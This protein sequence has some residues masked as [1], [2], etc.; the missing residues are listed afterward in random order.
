MI[1][2]SIVMRQWRRAQTIQSAPV[3]IEVPDKVRTAH[4][5][6]LAAWDAER[7][8]TEAL[9]AEPSDAANTRG[10][11]PDLTRSPGRR[12]SRRHGAREPQGLLK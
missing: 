3:A 5:A 10:G 4:G 7:G 9:R 2:A 12:T 8:E 1:A 11:V 6:A